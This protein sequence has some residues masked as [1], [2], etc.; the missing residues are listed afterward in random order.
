[1]RMKRFQTGAIAVAA[2]LLFVSRADA[3]IHGIDVSHF[4][5]TINW[6]SVK[7]AGIKFAFCKA[8]E[9]VDFEDVNFDTYMTNAI[10]ARMPIGPYHF[11]RLNS[12][13][14]I[15]TDAIDEANDFVDAIE[16]YYLG[17]GLVL[18]PV[19]DLE[20]LPDP[21]VSPSVKAYT[22]EWVR[23]FVGVVESR[24]GFAPIIYTGGNIAINYVEPDIA[25]N[26]LWFAKPIPPTP[27]DPTDV[28][29]QNNINNVSPPTDAQMG[30]WSEWKFWQW[31]WEG[32]ISGI[33]GNV[34][35]DVFYG[36][37]E[38]LADYIPGFLPGDYNADGVVDARDYTRW[39]D[40]LGKN[41]PTGTGADGNLDGTVSQADFNVWVNHY[42]AT[43]GAG[44]GAG[45]AG[46]T[47]APES[48]TC[49]L[50]AIGSAIV[51]ARTSRLRLRF[52]PRR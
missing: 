37:T 39:R 40:T 32:A 38:Q 11:G 47:P 35:R 26:D 22:S 10:A 50:L 48:S 30:I 34:D 4:Q 31:S 29:Y 20:T 23:D 2:M 44:S 16:P 41:V 51:A 49:I 18:R 13:E 17:T 36:T 12:G 25:Q 7:N 8:T 3:V 45:A 24:L 9:G 28:A 33:S 43:A 21:P 5:G 46:A 1:M 42:G 15:P 6:T 14:T 27:E 19:L 52:V